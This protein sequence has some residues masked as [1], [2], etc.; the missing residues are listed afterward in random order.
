MRHNK[1]ETH[2]A[3][4]DIRPRR[5][6]HVFRIEGDGDL[7][8]CDDRTAKTHHLS[9]PS[10]EV[11]NALDGKSSLE[12]VARRLTQLFDVDYPDALDDVEHLVAKFEELGLLEVT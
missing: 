11:W 2:W 10:C 7:L 1:D 8:L 5:S 12:D 9:G 4:V 3:L 6:R